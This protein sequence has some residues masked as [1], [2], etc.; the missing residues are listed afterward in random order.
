M[1]LCTLLTIFQQVLKI[2]SSF[3]VHMKV[4]YPSTGFTKGPFKYYVVQREGGVGG[5]WKL[6]IYYGVLRYEGTW[7]CAI[8]E[9]NGAAKPHMKRM[10]HS[11][12][13]MLIA[14]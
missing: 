9:V 8:F 13:R 12:F 3:Y 11:S 1:R 4:E 7:G 10:Q 14:S 5:S 2:F 6:E